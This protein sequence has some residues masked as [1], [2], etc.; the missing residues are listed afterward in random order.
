MPNMGG[1]LKA[2]GLGPLTR[3]LLAP[4]HWSGHLPIMDESLERTDVTGVRPEARAAVWLEAQHRVHMH[5]CTHAC[6]VRRAPATHA[7]EAS[8]RCDLRCL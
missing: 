5:A 6:A 3:R 7:L 4:S 8:P 1:G 2:G